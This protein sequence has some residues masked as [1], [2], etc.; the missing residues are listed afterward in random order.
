VNLFCVV[1]FYGCAG[2]LTAKNGGFRPAQVDAPGNVGIGALN[3]LH[4]AESTVAAGEWVHWAG[5]YDGSTMMMYL[6]GQMVLQDASSQSG[7]INYPDVGYGATAGGWFTL[8]A[9]HDANECVTPVPVR[10]ALPTKSWF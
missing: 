7:D 3:Y 6:N 4:G 1:F 2:R 10:E 9:Y 5:T 8:G